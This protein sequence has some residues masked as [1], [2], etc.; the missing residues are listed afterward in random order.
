M[1]FQGR[2]AEVSMC[3]LGVNMCSLVSKGI[4]G[5]VALMIDEICIC[6]WCG[7]RGV[8]V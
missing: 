7:Q 5:K 6:I 1:Y 2:H 8:V 3:M 4:S